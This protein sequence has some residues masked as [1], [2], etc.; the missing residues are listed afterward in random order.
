MNKYLYA[1]IIVLFFQQNAISQQKEIS[2]VSWNIQKFGS[3]KDANEIKQI[4]NILRDYDIIAIQEVVAGYGGA[5]AVARLVEE[6]NRKGAKWTYAVS[7]PT[8]SPKYLLERYAFIWKNKYIKIKNR[9]HL[10]SNLASV[11]DREPFAI[12]FYFNKKKF[13]VINYHARIFNKHPENEIKPLLEYIETIKTPVILTADFN[14]K[15][16]DSV[17]YSFKNKGFTEALKN[18]RTTLKKKCVKDNYLNY[19]I[20][21][22]FYSK[23]FIKIEAQPIDFVMYCDNLINARNLSDHLPVLLRFKI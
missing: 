9:G 15:T 10:L 7:N 12:D 1:F 18:K 13:T 22:I 19:A 11:I 21:N 23:H 4:A 20:D 17:F 5:Q 14:I 8:K 6:L 3:K 16:S 2:I